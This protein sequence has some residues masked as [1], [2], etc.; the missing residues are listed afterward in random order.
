MKKIRK[1]RSPLI[2]MLLIGSFIVFLGWSA[3]QAATRGSDITDRDYYSK[4]LKYNSTL[5]E[6]NA[7]SALGWQV[8]VALQEQ[9]LDIFLRDRQ[10]QPVTSGEATLYLYQTSTSAPLELRLAEVRPGTYRLVLPGNL[11]GEIRGRLDIHREGARINRNLLL[12]L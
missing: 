3:R 8:D 12:S 11:S 7:A 6:K 4:G 1:N 10:N 5:I 2:I 9:S